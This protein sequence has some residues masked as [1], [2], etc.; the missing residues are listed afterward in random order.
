M[1][2]INNNSFQISWKG[3]GRKQTGSRRGW[4]ESGRMQLTGSACL[5]LLSSGI[6]ESSLTGRLVGQNTLLLLSSHI[7]W[8]SAVRVYSACEHR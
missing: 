6:T 7:G 8:L 1:R 2:V 5:W 4:D 3:P